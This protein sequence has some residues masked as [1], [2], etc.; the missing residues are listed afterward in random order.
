MLLPGLHAQAR[1]PDGS[2]FAVLQKLSSLL[3][4]KKLSEEDD[5]E[6]KRLQ[7]LLCIQQVGVRGVACPCVPSAACIHGSLLRARL[8][9]AAAA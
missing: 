1:V 2:P 5:T 6:L 8:P 7:R 3:E 9:H 4:K